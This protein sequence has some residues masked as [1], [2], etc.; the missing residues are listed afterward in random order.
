MVKEY[1]SDKRPSL[2]QKVITESHLSAT[3]RY[4]CKGTQGSHDSWDGANMSKLSCNNRESHLAHSQENSVK[5]WN[6]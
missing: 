3:G 2:K 6:F 1:F 5:H 4:H